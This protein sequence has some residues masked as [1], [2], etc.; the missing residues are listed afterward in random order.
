MVILVMLVFNTKGMVMEMKKLGFT[1][2]GLFIV[3][4]LVFGIWFFNENA[5]NEKFAMAVAI[6]FPIIGLFTAFKANK[7]AL[8]LVGIAGNLLVLIFAVVIPA[9]SRLFWNQP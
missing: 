2:V 7:G 8:K 3:S 9:A 1:S 5:I 4:I 6:I